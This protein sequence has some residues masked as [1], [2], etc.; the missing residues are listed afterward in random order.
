MF[1][2][3]ARHEEKHIDLWVDALCINQESPTERNHQVGLMAEIYQ[4]ARLVTI[5]LGVAAEDDMPGLNELHELDSRLMGLQSDA[6]RIELVDPVTLNSSVI[7]Q[8]IIDAITP[9]LAVVVAK[10]CTKDYWTRTWVI[11]EFLLAGR[12]CVHFGGHRISWACFDTLVKILKKDVIIGRSGDQIPR[13]EAHLVRRSAAA[14]LASIRR[15]SRFSAD[16]PVTKHQHESRGLPYWMEAFQGAKCSVMHDKVYGML[17]L[18]GRLAFGHL[19]PVDYR[20]PL[21]DLV[22]DTLRL[23]PVDDSLAFLKVLLSS[24]QIERHWLSYLLSRGVTP[25][26]D[27]G[28]TLKPQQLG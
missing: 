23:C 24:L 8:Q 18:A 9:A 2:H 21:I 11:Q 4:G 6:T 10:L 5:W 3:H 26:L 7:L 19:F 20:M 1:L 13:S 16:L 17:G 12:L 28:Y 25:G 27:V 22:M 14:R 15:P